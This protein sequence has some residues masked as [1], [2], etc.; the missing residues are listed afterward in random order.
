MLKDSDGNVELA[1]PLSGDTS[2]PSFGLSGLLTLLVK[3][4]TMSATKDYLITTFVPY[5]SVM[6]VAMAAGEYALKL[7]IND[8]T[9]LPQQIELNEEQIEFSRQMSVMLEDRSDI[10]VKLCAIA[11]PQDI[12]LDNGDDA[13]LEDNVKRLQ[14][15]STQRVDSFKSYMVEKLKV[16][17]AKLLRC[18]PQVDTSK[19]AKARIEFVI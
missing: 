12:G 4:A 5:A 10:N 13:L 19:N 6:K 3:Q 9:Y 11:I 15:I 14:A 8:L 17:S 7:R 16:P 2:S 18:T 1:L